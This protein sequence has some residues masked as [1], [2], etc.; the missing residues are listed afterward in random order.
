LVAQFDDAVS[1]V[2]IGLLLVWHES[3]EAGN[4]PGTGHMADDM[5]VALLD[6]FA[7]FV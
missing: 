4:E 2:M 1:E 3:L 5:W 7:A 6:R